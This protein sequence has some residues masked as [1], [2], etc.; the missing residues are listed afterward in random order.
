MDNQDSV[1]NQGAD[2][3]QPPAPRPF[4]LK[5]WVVVVLVLIAA[6]AIAVTWFFV[7]GSDRGSIAGR[8]VPAPAGE[9]VPMP[10]AAAG[11]APRAGEIVITL[12]PDK[13]ENARLKTEVVAEQAGA[14]VAGAGASV[15]GGSVAGTVAG[16]PQAPSKKLAIRNR[17]ASV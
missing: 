14:S 10:D 17:H 9:S 1:M 6:G 13:L 15:A 5:R 8:P 2:S 11:T 7:S 4:A 3:G 16:A 12:S